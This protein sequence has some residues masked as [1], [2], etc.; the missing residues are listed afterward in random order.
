MSGPHRTRAGLS[1]RT[2]GSKDPPS[3][4]RPQGISDSHSVVRLR[5]P[6][7]SCTVEDLD[8]AGG[9]ANQAFVALELAGARAEQQR[10]ALLDERERIAADLYDHVIQRLFA[11]GPSLQALA[12]ILARARPPTAS[13]PPSPTSTPRSPRSASAPSSPSS[14]FPSWPP[15]AAS[16]PV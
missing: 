7:Y 1:T 16:P 5:E 11:S 14:R 2:A 10:A 15:W 6:T 4:C 12:A 8:M 13:W 3:G 9:F